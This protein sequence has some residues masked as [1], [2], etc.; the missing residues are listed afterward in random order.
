MHSNVHP[1]Y[2]RANSFPTAIRKPLGFVG[3]RTETMQSHPDPKFRGALELVLFKYCNVTLSK[4]RF[5][6]A[7]FFKGHGKIYF[8]EPGRLARKGRR[9]ERKERVEGKL[10]PETQEN[11]GKRFEPWVPL[12]LFSFF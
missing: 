5:L 1:P 9:K 11:S 2:T 4:Q 8:G 10:R 6:C 12:P 7:L 3:P